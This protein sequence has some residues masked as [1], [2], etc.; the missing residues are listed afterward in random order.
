MKYALTSMLLLTTLAC[1][2][3]AP[4]PVTA[5]PARARTLS[6]E[7]TA[8]DT[9]RVTELTKAREAHAAGKLSD[10]GLARVRTAGLR[11]EAAVKVASSELRVYLASGVEGE[12]VLAAFDELRAARTNLELTIAAKTPNASTSKSRP[13]RRLSPVLLDPNR[14]GLKEVA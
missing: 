2:S 6:A 9:Y 4:K 8:A 1:S 3:A 5:N 12:R 13:L 11:L 7:I 14:F 10:E